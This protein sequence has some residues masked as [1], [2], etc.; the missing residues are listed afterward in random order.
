MS[1][2]RRSRMMSAKRPINSRKNITQRVAIAV[3][4][5]VDV[6]DI[7]DTVDVLPALAAT[8]QVT[9]GSIV[10]TVYIEA[11][12]MGNAVEG[13]NSPFVWQLRKNP[14]NNLTF[15]AP[16]SAG[17]DDNKRFVFAMGKGLIGSQVNGQPGYVIRGWFKIP[18]NYR[19]MGHD[20]TVQL[21]IENN[22]A[23]DL[24][25]CELFIYKWYF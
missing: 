23:N 17:A 20:D 5:A 13:V 4:A 6:T 25:I 24:N 21:A 2:R 16:S 18:K 9:A 15:A 19:R 8:N 3:A 1:F 22:T 14:G 11:W 10:N 12:I 7:V